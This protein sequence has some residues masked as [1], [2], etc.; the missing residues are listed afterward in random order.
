[1]QGGV[2]QCF[3][4]YAALPSGP[5]ACGDPIST[6]GN[7]TSAAQLAGLLCTTYS[8]HEQAMM[9]VGR[10][11]ENEGVW[12]ELLVVWMLALSGVGGS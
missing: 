5:L 9:K 2:C 1:M 3:P 8:D 7:V 12:D 10:G 4:G 6:I 11:Q